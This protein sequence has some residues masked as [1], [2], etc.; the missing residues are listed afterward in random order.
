MKKIIF[1][2]AAVL[3]LSSCMIKTEKKARTITVTG[4]GSITVEN[5]E[6]TLVLS[7]ISRNEDVVKASEENA[8][9]M[10]AV[11][12]AVTEA[13]VG[14]D[15]MQTSDYSIRQEEAERQAGKKS[16]I[17]YVVSNRLHITVKDVSRTGKI[18]DAAIKAGANQMTSLSYSAGDTSEAEKQ[19]RILAVR[20]ADQKAN[21]LVATSGLTLGQVLSISEREG[22]YS[23]VRNAVLYKTETAST[24]I[25]GGS[26]SVSVTIDVTY[27]LQ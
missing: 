2:A 16:L 11:M 1:I 15:S 7:V 9:K 4:T 26:T 13:G 18:I 19:A 22:Y 3:S 21:V 10:T 14:T 17:Q 6:A 8:E 20:D 25:S 12:K 5:K 24:P 27:E 23:P